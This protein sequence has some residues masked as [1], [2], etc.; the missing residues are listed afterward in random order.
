MSFCPT[1]T[2]FSAWLD[3]TSKHTWH[4]IAL[5]WRWTG[6]VA[7]W[8]TETRDEAFIWQRRDAPLE[9]VRWLITDLHAGWEFLFPVLWWDSRPLKLQLLFD[10]LLLTL[11]EE[12]G[13]LVAGGRQSAE[14]STAMFHNSGLR[15][16]SWVATYW[17]VRHSFRAAFCS[18]HL[19]TMKKPESLQQL[20]KAAQIW[21][22]R[23]QKRN[24]LQYQYYCLTIYVSPL[25]G[26]YF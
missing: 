2:W 4:V 25:I 23:Q 5:R 3:A 22:Q 13:V 1:I 24:R 10:V 21:R 6:A 17:T 8:I 18:R 15:W 14:L 11:L 16:R 9:A 7:A 26:L 20:L 19:N 12:G